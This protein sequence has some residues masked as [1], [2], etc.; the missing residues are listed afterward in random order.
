MK[1]L[2]V[3]EVGDTVEMWSRADIWIS[4]RVNALYTYGQCS[5]A[6]SAIDTRGSVR[7]GIMLID[8]KIPLDPN[9]R[10]PSRG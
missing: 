7:S 8:G 2:I 5:I 10:L 3:L 4:S 1:T 6:F 9:W